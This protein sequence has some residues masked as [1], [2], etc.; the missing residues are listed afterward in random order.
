MNPSTNF[1]PALF[2]TVREIELERR[3]ADLERALYRAKY[4]NAE[5]I[6]LTPTTVEVIREHAAPPELTI[7]LPRVASIDTRYDEGMPNHV[8]IAAVAT[9]PQPFGLSYYCDLAL[10]GDISI[11]TQ[12]LGMLH[13]RFIHQLAAF[14]KKENAKN[15][16][17]AN[18]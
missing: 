12:V 15:E 10:L 14:V 7:K 13:E 2:K 18:T 8:Q 5:G 4:G 16:T 1:S 9:V 6:M 17:S 3:V 11:A